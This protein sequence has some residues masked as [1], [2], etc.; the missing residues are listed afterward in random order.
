MT[1]EN[2]VKSALEIA[3]EKTKNLDINPDSI[4]E[5]ENLE[6]GKRLGADLLRGKNGSDIFSILDS[7]STAEKRRVVEGVEFGSPI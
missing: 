7:K 5:S 3:L 2:E 1:E 4:K 6:L